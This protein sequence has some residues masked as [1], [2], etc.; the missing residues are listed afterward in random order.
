MRNKSPKKNSVEVNNV[1]PTRLE[2]HRMASSETERISIK[3]PVIS[4]PIEYSSL[5]CF[6][7]TSS[8][9]YATRRMQIKMEITWIRG[10]MGYL[11]WDFLSRVTKIERNILNT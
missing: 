8:K 2:T 7:L 1:A 3:V 9:T 4:Q 11:F 6:L 5:K 10:G